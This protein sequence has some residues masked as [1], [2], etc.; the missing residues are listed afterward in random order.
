MRKEKKEKKE[1]FKDSVI[2]ETRSLVIEKELRNY[3]FD[4][5]SE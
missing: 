2:L 4:P 5:G 3:E 1:S